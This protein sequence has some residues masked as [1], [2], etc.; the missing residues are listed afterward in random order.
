MMKP[1]RAHR[2]LFQRGLQ[3]AAMVL[4][5]PSVA[6][7]QWIWQEVGFPARSGHCAVYASGM[8]IFGGKEGSTLRNDVWML[9]GSFWDPVR[10]SGTPPTPRAGHTAIYDPVRKRLIVFGGNDGARSNEV[11]ALTLD[12]SSDPTWTQ[13]LPL[14]TPPSAREGHVA[15]YDPVGDRMIVFGGTDGAALNDVWSL[16]LANPPTWTLLSPSGPPPSPRQGACAAYDSQ[17]QRILLFGGAT[18]SGYGTGIWALDLAGGMA[19]SEIVASGTAPTPRVH[20][21]ALYDPAADRFLIVGGENLTGDF[22]VLDGAQLALSGTPTWQTGF[23]ANGTRGSLVYDSAHGRGLFYGGSYDAIGTTN[24]TW[25]VQLTSTP[26]LTRFVPTSGP[27]GL[28]DES[29]VLAYAGDEARIVVFGG[30]TIGGFEPQA[31]DQTFA[32]DIPNWSGVANP[33]PGLYYDWVPYGSGTPPAARY[34]HSAIRDVDH[35][36]MIVFGGHSFSASPALRNDLWSLAFGTGVWSPLAPSGLGP[37]GRFEHS[38]IYDAPAHRMIVFGGNTADPFSSPPVATNE[39]WQLD[40]SL[41]PPAWSQL[42]PLGT[43]PPARFGHSAIHDLDHHR[44]VVF[45]GSDAAGGLFND[46]WSLSLDGPPTWTQIVPGGTPPSPRQ[47]HSAVFQGW[48]TSTRRML[49]YGGT[50]SRE[51]W[52]LSLTGAPSWTQLAVSGPLPDVWQSHSAVSLQDRIGQTNSWVMLVLGGSSASPWELELPGV[53]GVDPSI[54]SGLDL[55]GAFPNPAK[56]SLTV[57]FTL[58]DAGPARLELFDLAGRKVAS[59][60]VGAL[61]PG[62]HVVRLDEHGQLSPGLYLVK[63]TRTSESRVAKVVLMR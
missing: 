39:L 37:S 5:L 13:L 55:E 47:E 34:G 21:S 51:V 22:P 36:Q 48:S 61:G 57:A 52:A 19:W 42:S 50:S 24:Q 40:L 58:P 29:A 63:L 15:I 16:S 56:A 32:L 43:P 12:P 28:N 18:D 30:K 62:R 41:A 3:L 11:W 2:P 53:V 35:N 38:A 27:N 45:G 10:V 23:F 26:S 6:S 49:V 9:G 7:A 20:A 59:R 60:D 17:R 54:P 33:P 25:T 14:G 1:S 8:W 46:V 31:S 44:M 4:L